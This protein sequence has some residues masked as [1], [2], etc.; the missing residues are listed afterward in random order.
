MNECVRNWFC[1]QHLGGPFALWHGCVVSS[2][3]G[4]IYRF[5]TYN[6]FIFVT[7]RGLEGAKQRK[8]NS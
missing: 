8:V 5:A 4:S 1:S 7:L 3:V 2:I 6:S